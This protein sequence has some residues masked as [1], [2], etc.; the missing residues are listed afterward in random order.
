MKT[1][2]TKST[3]FMAKQNETVTETQFQYETGNLKS[4]AVLQE[5]AYLK[6]QVVN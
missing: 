6:L 1:I 4:Q 2:K 3:V 5:L